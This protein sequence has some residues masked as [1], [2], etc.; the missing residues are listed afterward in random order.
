[1]VLD[2]KCTQ[3]MSTGPLNQW[4]N[5]LAL[6]A[7]VNLGI[8]P[9]D[10]LQMQ[11]N[12]MELPTMSREGAEMPFAG[13]SATRGTG[14]MPYGGV[15]TPYEATYSANVNPYGG[16]SAESANQL[17]RMKMDPR[18]M[19]LLRTFQEVSIGH[20][21]QLFGKW[22]HRRDSKPSLGFTD[23]SD[24]IAETLG[25]EPHDPQAVEASAST[26]LR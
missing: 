4:M 25:L 22:S 6:N 8:T 15:P 3:L 17:G 2:R 10:A 5:S 24:L 7:N 13:T 16:T 26:C 14:A 18:N 23:F 19:M 21:K 12:G 1:M 9:S 20:L 11:Y